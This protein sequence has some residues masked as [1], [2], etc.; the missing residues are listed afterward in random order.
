MSIVFFKHLE[1]CESTNDE[2]WKIPKERWPAVVVTELQTKGRGQQGRIW[3]AAPGVQVLATL[4]FKPEIESEKLQMLPLIA[5]ECALE[6][7]PDYKHLLRLKWPNDIYAGEKKLGGILC[8]SKFLG[9][10]LQGAAVGI[11]LNIMSSP[12]LAEQK[13]TSL[14][15]LL[16]MNRVDVEF[17]KNFRKNFLETWANRMLELRF[18]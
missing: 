7:L 10:Q 8:E 12:L 14:F 6:S 16:G 13:T 15:E 1:E 18:G 17:A 9:S 2:A 3:Q 4:I 11:G 5:G